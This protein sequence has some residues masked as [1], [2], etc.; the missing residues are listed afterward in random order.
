MFSIIARVLVSLM[1]A[2]KGSEASESG[3]YHILVLLMPGTQKEKRLRK[4]FTTIARKSM[5]KEK[6]VRI[7]HRLKPVLGGSPVHHGYVI[8]PR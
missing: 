8:Y 5:M 7:R 4:Q 6:G 2:Q 3:L 1:L